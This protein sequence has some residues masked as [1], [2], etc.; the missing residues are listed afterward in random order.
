M[1]IRPA[2]VAWATWARSR[3]SCCCSARCRAARRPARR[4]ECRLHRSIGFAAPSRIR[5]TAPEG[6]RHRPSE[7]RGASPARRADRREHTEHGERSQS[8]LRPDG[9]PSARRSRSRP[10]ASQRRDIT[11]SGQFWPSD[12]RGRRPHS[13]ALRATTDP[14]GRPRRRRPSRSCAGSGL[15][16]ASASTSGAGVLQ[17]CSFRVSSACGPEHDFVG[18]RGDRGAPIGGGVLGAR[19]GAEAVVACTDG[20]RRHTDCLQ[21]QG[22]RAPAQARV[23]T[24]THGGLR[25]R[26]HA[27]GHDIDAHL[28]LRA[29]GKDQ[30][31]GA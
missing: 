21:R 7:D 30:L 5:R 15:R 19:V 10:T 1:R 9:L 2:C 3:T 16:R 11:R 17:A 28:L 12:T 26:Q 13:P 14:R 8:A 31:G 18:E 4:C 29:R 23:V 24:Q 22:P 25:H 20:Q 27:L 6:A